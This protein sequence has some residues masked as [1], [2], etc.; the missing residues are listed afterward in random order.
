MKTLVVHERGTRS[1]HGGILLLSAAALLIVLACTA[2]AVDLGFIAL[3]KSQ[4]QVA[5]DAAALGAAL[6][7]NIQANQSTVEGAVRSGAVELAALH[8]A[9]GYDSVLLDS[10]A[11]MQVGQA[12]WNP[13]SQIYEPNFIAGLTPFNL[14]KVTARLKQIELTSDGSTVDRRVPLFFARMFGHETA[15]L[16][17]TATAAVL[18]GV[19]FR[20]ESNSNRHSGVLPFALD[21]QTWL[22]MLSGIGTDQYSFDSETQEVSSGSDGVLEVNLY[23]E[24]TSLLPPGNRGT[25]DFGKPANSSSDIARQIL[26]GLNAEDLSVFGGELRTDLGPLFV[27][28]DT[29]ISAGFKEELEEIIGEP[30]A[31]PL[32]TEVSGPGDNATYTVVRFVGIRIVAV[33]LSG[34]GSS[35]Y[36]KVQPAHFID[37]TVIAGKSTIILQPGTILTAPQLIH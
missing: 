1:R 11:D 9:A 7:F 36:V 37:S 32:F 26:H 3:A 22:N 13:A 24:G 5:A 19:G 16:E 31:I 25:L 18:P 21:E 34:S 12:A 4:L 2:F 14:V 15:E 35:K 33:K 6:E 27:D 17:V 30:R 28:G 20:V 23:P 10:T 29:G 8:R